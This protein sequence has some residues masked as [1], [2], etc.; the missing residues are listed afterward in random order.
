MEPRDVNQA[1]KVAR[2]TS[3][4]GIDFLDARR[5]EFSRTTYH[6]VLDSQGGN[7][8]QSARKIKTKVKFQNKD[9]IRPF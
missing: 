4:E 1:S 9:S 7:V 6:H 8:E 2:G 5:H 3:L